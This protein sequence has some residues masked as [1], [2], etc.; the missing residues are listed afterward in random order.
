MPKPYDQVRSC[1]TRFLQL[2]RADL[3]P[4]QLA[5]VL[6]QCVDHLLDRFA[7][8]RDDAYDVALAAWS[9]YAGKATGCYVDLAVSTPHLVFVADPVAGVRY[10]IPLADLLK[11]IGP[12]VIR[13]QDPAAAAG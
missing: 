5:G 8:Q 6:S 3:P 13:T 4:A 9:E 11:F 12:R 10:P 7:M 2:Y 1:A